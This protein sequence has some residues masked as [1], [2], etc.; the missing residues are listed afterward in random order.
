VHITPKIVLAAKT[1]NFPANDDMTFDGCQNGITPFATP[2]CTVDANN[3]DLADNRYFNEA[4]LKSPADIR[5][6]ATGTKFEPPQSSKVSYA[7]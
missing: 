7:C 4:T 1:L 3:S 6:H 2:W 5:R